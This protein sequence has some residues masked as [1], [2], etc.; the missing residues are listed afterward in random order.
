ML[1]SPSSPDIQSVRLPCLL[2][3]SRQ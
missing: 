1:V 2:P 3:T